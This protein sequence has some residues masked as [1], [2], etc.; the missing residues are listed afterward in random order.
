MMT[1]CTGSEQHTEATSPQG[2]ACSCGLTTDCPHEELHQQSCLQQDV[3]WPTKNELAE[4][5]L[6]TARLKNPKLPIT[7]YTR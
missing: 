2:V 1:L 4:H 7:T 3:G 6:L 5:K